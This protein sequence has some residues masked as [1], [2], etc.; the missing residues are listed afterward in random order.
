MHSLKGGGRAITGLSNA[1]Q[2]L[3][4][5][6]QAMQAAGVNETTFVNP[7]TT[8]YATG[9]SSSTNSAPT[10]VTPQITQPIEFSTYSGV[11]TDSPYYIPNYAPLW[12][13]GYRNP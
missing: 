12:A 9:N 2:N 4:N 13:Q 5:A 11:S 10:A 6:M 3:N 1:Q 8:N 7:T